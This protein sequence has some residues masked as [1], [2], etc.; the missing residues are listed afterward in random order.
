MIA[1]GTSLLH[2]STVFYKYKFRYV[3]S[4]CFSDQER[5]V[6]SSHAQAHWNGDGSANVGH[7]EGWGQNILSVMWPM[8]YCYLG[9]GRSRRG[10][11]SSWQSLS[12][13]WRSYSAAEGYERGLV[14]TRWQW[15]QDVERAGDWS[16]WRQR[17]GCLHTV[18]PT[19]SRRG[20]YSM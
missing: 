16:V 14:W 12:D 19:S 18:R 1:T 20:G 15:R 10:T 8:R 11:V 7:L 17:V 3:C 9:G 6:T 13:N 5:W 2:F 4:S